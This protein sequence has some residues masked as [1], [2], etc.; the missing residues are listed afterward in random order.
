[1][2]DYTRFKDIVYEV[3]GASMDVYNELGFGLREP[4]YQEA[5]ALEL[6]SRGILCE[7]EKMVHIYYKGQ[8][9][10]QFYKLDLLV[11]NEIIVETKGVF[12]LSAEHRAQL[13][14]Y[15]RLTHKPV[16]LLINFGD[17]DNLYGERYVLDENNICFRV[18]KN[19]R[20]IP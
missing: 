15:M 12:E 6:H 7:R 4:V 13:F 10:K 14:N 9:L 20:P 8:E 11:E 18:D 19:M 5:L 17:Y 3:I 1:M 16:G 2:E